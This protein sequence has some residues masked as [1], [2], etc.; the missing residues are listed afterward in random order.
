MPS[1]ATGEVIVELKDKS[2][3]KDGIY[4]A[5]WPPVAKVGNNEY[6]SIDEA[7]AAW[8]NNTTLTLLSDVTLSDVVKIKSTEART[9]DLGTYTLTAASGKNAIE[10]TCEGRANASYALTVNADATNPGGITAKGK[11]CIY[12]SKSGST[13]DRPIIRIYNGVFNGSYSINSKSNGNTNCPQIWIYGGTFNGNVNLTK[14]M[15]RVFGGTFHGWINCTGDTNAYREITG[16]RF[17]SWQF[18]TADDSLVKFGVG[19]R[20]SDNTFSYNVGCYV[21]DDNYLVV[22]GDPITKF[23][24]R[25]EAKAECSAWSSCLKYSSAAGGLY[26]TKIENIPGMKNDPPKEDKVLER[27]PNKIF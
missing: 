27:N 16:G 12:Y 18:M 17:K 10:V 13:K 22:G 26:Y 23:D 21:D 4:G 3:D 25:F 8:T 24:D 1:D 19:T 20:N 7:I 5:T 15:L 14:N 6:Y 9:L 2:L 11:A